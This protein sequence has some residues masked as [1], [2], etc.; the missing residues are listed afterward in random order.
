MKIIAKKEPQYKPKSILYWRIDICVFYVTLHSQSQFLS[1]AF[2]PVIWLQT[3]PI[4]AQFTHL[5][6]YYYLLTFSLL[7][8]PP[9]SL[10]YY[11]LSPWCFSHISI[12]LSSKTPWKFPSWIFWWLIPSFLFFGRGFFSLSK[13]HM[14]FLPFLYPSFRAVNLFTATQ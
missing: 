9:L 2:K 8:F 5:S 12:S 10:M 13:I 3:F 14:L 7:S 6:Y 1:L 11:P 4:F